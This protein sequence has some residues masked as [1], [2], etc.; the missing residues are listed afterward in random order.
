M[1]TKLDTTT[2]D[3]PTDWANKVISAN[4]ASQVKRYEIH[5]V[6][7][8]AGTTPNMIYKYSNPESLQNIPGANLMLL[9]RNG[10][11]QGE[12]LIPSLFHSPPYRLSKNGFGQASGDVAGKTAEL[13]D[14]ATL[15]RQAAQ[16]GDAQ[17]M[18]DICNDLDDLMADLRA[19]TALVSARFKRDEP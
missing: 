2:K 1:R 8:W 19:E 12:I 14:K 17:R 3:N 6:A 10:C 4:I 18:K 7:E 13:H 5:T 11:S 16:A 9:S 15:F